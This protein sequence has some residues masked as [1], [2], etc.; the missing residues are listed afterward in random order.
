MTSTSV[1]LITYNFHGKILT[2]WPRI[3]SKFYILVTFSPYLKEKRNIRGLV[4]GSNMS[5]DTDSPRSLLI[6][7]AKRVE[8]EL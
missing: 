6:C 3:L 7:R 1:P 2:L 8:V 5:I 4:C